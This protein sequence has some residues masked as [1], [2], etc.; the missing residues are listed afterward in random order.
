MNSD[1]IIKK[2]QINNREGEKGDG[3]DEHPL[4]NLGRALRESVFPISDKL[5]FI[6]RKLNLNTT[7]LYSDNSRH[8]SN[9]KA[10]VKMLS[11]YGPWSDLSRVEVVDVVEIVDS[12]RYT[13][14][15]IGKNISTGDF[16]KD[17][18]T[19]MSVCLVILFLSLRK[20]QCLRL[21]SPAPFLGWRHSY[22]QRW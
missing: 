8:P 7:K 10:V 19:K 9:I 1:L 5:F 21:R 11:K 15:L 22:Q 12:V 14:G 13:T 6:G 4:S 3:G 17:W 2:T 18:R 16:P 20:Q